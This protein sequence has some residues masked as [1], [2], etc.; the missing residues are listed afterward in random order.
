MYKMYSWLII[1]MLSI[2][3]CNSEEY[4][5]NQPNYSYDNS[6]IINNSTFNNLINNND[7][8]ENEIDDSQSLTSINPIFDSMVYNEIIEDSIE[9]SNEILMEDI[10]EPYDNFDNVIDNYTFLYNMAINVGL[11][12]FS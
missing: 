5:V 1:I 11:V 12:D 9:I 6:G 8:E 2:T 4:D 7:T 3:S 10:N